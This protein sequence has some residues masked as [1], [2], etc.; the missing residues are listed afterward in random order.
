VWMVRNTGVNSPRDPHGEQTSMPILANRK[1][2]SR[3]QARTQDIRFYFEV[4]SHHKGVLLPIEEP[5]QGRVFSNPNPPQP[6]HQ[7]QWNFF[8]NLLTRAG[9]TNFL[10]SSTTLETSKQPQ[11]V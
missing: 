10:G 9:N 3:I 8:S 1:S 4:R 6:D 5:T 11:S 2:Q 7:G